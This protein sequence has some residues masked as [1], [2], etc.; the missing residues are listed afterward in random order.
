[1][2]R[3]ILESKVGPLSNS[4]FAE[5][6]DLTTTDIKIN[7]VAFKQRTSTKEAL[8]IALSCFTALQRGKV[9]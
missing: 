3:A 8:D 2:L 1:M 6:M 9:A 4:V 5:V 7:R